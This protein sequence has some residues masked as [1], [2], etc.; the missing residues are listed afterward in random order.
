MQRPFFCGMTETRT[1]TLF[2]AADF[3]TTMTF[4]TARAFVVWTV[5]WPCADAGRPRPSSLYTFRRFF[6]A[7]WLGVVTHRESSPNLSASRRSFPVRR[8]ISQVCCVCLFHHHPS[9][10]GLRQAHQKA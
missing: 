9:D 4:A 1:R 6:R 2:R 3:R 5:P 10:L 8:L 7:A